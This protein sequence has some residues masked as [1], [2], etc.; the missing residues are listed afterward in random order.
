MAK[1]AYRGS[2]FAEAVVRGESKKPLYV[3]ARG[4][5]QTAAARWVEQMHGAYRIPTLL[6]LVDRLVRS[7]L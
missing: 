7:V 4:I 1:N 5:D 3:T 6:K 2:A